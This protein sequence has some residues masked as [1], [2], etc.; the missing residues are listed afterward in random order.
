MK[1]GAIWPRRAKF[2]SRFLQVSGFLM[3]TAMRIATTLPPAQSDATA[4]AMLDRQCRIVARDEVAHVD[5]VDGLLSG[6]GQP[7]VLRQLKP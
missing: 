6:R 5:S 1:T 3:P 4:A 7:V 2:P